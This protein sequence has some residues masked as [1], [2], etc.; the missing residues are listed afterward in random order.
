[1]QDTLLPLRL[2][3]FLEGYWRNYGTV[4]ADLRNISGDSL[5][6]ILEERYLLAGEEYDISFRSPNFEDIASI[7]FG[8]ESTFGKIIDLLPNSLSGGGLGY[9][10]VT[11][12]FL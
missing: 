5:I 3:Y 8:I 7:Q 4:Y 6:F 11:D 12:E 10:L 9:N 2:R 1:G